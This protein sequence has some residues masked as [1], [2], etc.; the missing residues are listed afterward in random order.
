MGEVQ[1][2]PHT[3]PRETGFAPPSPGA[4][5]PP[6]PG[7][8]RWWADRLAGNRIRRPRV[9]GLSTPRIVEAAMDVLREDGVEALTLRAVADRLNTSSASLYRHITSRDE[10]MAL[11]ADHVLGNIR[12]PSS[13][14]GWRADVEALMHELRRVLLAQPLP[15]SAARS[16]SGY[17][18]NGLRLLDAALGMFLGAGLDTAQA[19]FATTTMIQFVAGVVDI[20]RSAAGRGSQGATRADGF[21][22]LLAGLDAERFTALRAAGAAYL[23]M[24]ADDVFSYGMNR[25][26]DG[27][28]GR[29]PGKRTHTPKSRAPQRQST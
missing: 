27:I 25:F 1:Q 5:T 26:L 13:E 15:P 12:L 8:A 6:E 11:M 4:S 7:S 19:A 24:P 29:L 18:P 17:G 2:H 9:G 22:Q 23:A 16:T 3:A 21:D 20:E 10:L 28:A 14:R